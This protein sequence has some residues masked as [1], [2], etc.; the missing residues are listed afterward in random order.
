VLNTS[1]L[2]YS[3]EKKIF[4]RANSELDGP[5][6]DASCDYICI[7]CKDKV[8]LKRLLNLPLQMV[9]GRKIPDELQQLSF[10]EKLLIAG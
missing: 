1:G 10:A 5:A 2:V 4:C 7:S 3:K 6:I 9:Y 8:R